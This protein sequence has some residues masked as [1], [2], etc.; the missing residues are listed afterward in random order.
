MQKAVLLAVSLALCS[1][2]GAFAATAQMR[3]VHLRPMMV[4]ILPDRTTPLYAR[5]SMRLTPRGRAWVA[6]ESQRLR[7]GTLDPSQVIGEAGPVCVG[8]FNSCNGGADIQALAF[9]ILMQATSDED[10]DLQA[11]MA[12]VKGINNAK[13]G[14]RR[15]M[16]K[17]RALNAQQINQDVQDMK[18]KLDS[19]SELGETE[20]LRLQMAMDR[21]S[22]FMQAISYIEKK[23]SDTDDSIIENSK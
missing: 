23:I 2:F 5:L 17:M 21:L 18:G 11:I 13:A 9:V 6:A 15:V 7:N 19:L 22:K 12:E 16:E 14:H 4:V 3:P 10:Q 8:A 1:M 20:G